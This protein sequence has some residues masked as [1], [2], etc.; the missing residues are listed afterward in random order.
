MLSPPD[1]LYLDHP[2]EH[3]YEARGNY[4]AANFTNTQ[5]VFEYSPIEHIDIKNIRN[6]EDN[7]LGKWV[8]LR[9]HLICHSVQDSFNF[10]SLNML[11]Y[12][13]TIQ[14]VL[15]ST[16]NYAVQHGCNVLLCEQNL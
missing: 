11:H 13:V 7:L 9:F 14:K 2:Y 8:I 6:G 5:K 15:Y 12:R 4:W 1:C 16:V 3:D 10:F